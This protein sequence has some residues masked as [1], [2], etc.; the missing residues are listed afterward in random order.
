M[1]IPLDRQSPEPLY[2]QIKAHLRQGIL[3]GGWKP[4]RACRPAASWRATWALIA[5]PWKTLIP[6]WKPMD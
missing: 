4:I 5:S 2:Q 3:S 1:R 6:N